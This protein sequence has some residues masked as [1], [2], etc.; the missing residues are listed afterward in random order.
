MDFANRTV[1]VT[2]AEGSSHEV[3]YATYKASLIYGLTKPIAWFEAKH[4]IRYVCI[5]PDPVF[6]KQAMAKIKTMLGRADDPQEI[7][8]LCLFVNSDKGQ[9]INGENIMIDGDRNAMQR[10]K[11]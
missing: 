1:I 8:D 7:I 5:S 3:D 4:V 10:S 11:Q 2:G 6:T 9:F